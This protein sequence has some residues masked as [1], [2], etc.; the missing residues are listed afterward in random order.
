MKQAG[1]RVFR[2]PDRFFVVIS[3]ALAVLVGYGL[4]HLVSGASSN[5]WKQAGVWVLGGVIF[6]EFLYA[7][8]PML[9]SIVPAFYEQIA[10][11]PGEFAILGLPMGRQRYHM[12]YQTFHEHPLVWGVISR[13]PAKAFRYIKNSPLLESLRART[14]P[15][16][17]LDIQEQLSG[18]GRHGVRYIIVHKYLLNPGKMGL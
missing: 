5:R 6:F 18:L 15:D 7:P 10:D 13:T 3:L 1:N 2:A 12:Y 4:A 8:F 16:P 17:G 14:A 9:Q 11:E